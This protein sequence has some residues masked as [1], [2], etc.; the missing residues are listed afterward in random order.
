VLRQERVDRLRSNLIET[1]GNGGLWR[2][3]RDV[4][5]FKM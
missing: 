1:E 3:N 5:T 4:I 2:G